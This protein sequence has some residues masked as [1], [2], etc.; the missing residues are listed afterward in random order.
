MQQ[1]NRED[2]QPSAPRR[3]PP[4]SAVGGC[5][6]RSD[7]RQTRRLA[8]E[9]LSRQG[10]VATRSENPEHQRLFAIPIPQ[11][12]DSTALV[13]S[14]LPEQTQ[15]TGDREVDAILWLRTVCKTTRDASI[16]D[17]A[18]E[19]AS[20]ITTPHDELE[21]RYTAWLRRQPGAH[22]LAVALSRIGE[23]KHHV[24]RARERILA[25]A[26]GLAAFGRYEV[27]MAPTTAEAMLEETAA[28][29]EGYNGWSRLKLDQLTDIFAR[30]V[31]PVSLTECVAELRY[32]RWL[33][34]IRWHM[35]ATE[36]PGDSL[37]DDPPI[38]NLRRQYVEGL[39]TMISPFDRAERLHVADVLKGGLIDTG[40]VDD[41]K[42]HA[43]VLDHL[44]RA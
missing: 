11:P 30:S 13:A 18:L 23:I 10:I 14:T 40:S 7:R 5:G 20:R 19:A 29:P 24:E 3:G 1:L 38:V 42:E 12:S 26:E 6:R 35:H 8:R 32:W 21:E 43:R 28:L 36:Y 4:L 31:N 37:E 2:A 15:I 27:A 22:P 34:Q 16:L 17:R 25:H 39:L 44:L 41:W 9:L 33:F